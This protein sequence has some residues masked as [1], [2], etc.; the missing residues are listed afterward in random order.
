MESVF[1]CVIMNRNL[2]NIIRQFINSSKKSD[3]NMSIFISLL[4]DRKNKLLEQHLSNKKYLKNVVRKD[5]NLITLVFQKASPNV[6]KILLADCIN[7]LNY[8]SLHKYYLI[9]LESNNTEVSDV[10]LKRLN[11]L[12][13]IRTLANILHFIM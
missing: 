5:A 3:K 6:L 10:L 8:D 12:N 2:F 11:G 7:K 13:K 1:R 4:K 9:A